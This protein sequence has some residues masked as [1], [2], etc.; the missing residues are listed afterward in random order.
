MHS[1]IK[2]FV[3]TLA[4]LSFG[5]LSACVVRSRPATYYAPRPVYV[6]QPQPVQTVYVAQPA[7]QTVYVAQPQPTTVYVR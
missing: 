7:P 5:S 3:V 4:L 6:A 2:G 1:M